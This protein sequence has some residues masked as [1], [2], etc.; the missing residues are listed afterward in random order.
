MKIFTLKYFTQFINK[1]D[2]NQ[3]LYILTF[4]KKM[5]Y[6]GINNIS[7]FNKVNYYVVEEM[8]PGTDSRLKS[9]NYIDKYCKVIVYNNKTYKLF[10]YEFE[11]DKDAADYCDLKVISNTN[12]NYKYSG[13]IFFNNT[14]RVYSGRY[15]YIIEGEN[16]FD[17]VDFY[18]YLSS[19]F[20]VLFS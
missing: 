9:L 1:L 7:E 13:N 10:A 15:A 11:S 20:T 8:N 5:E 16:H 4:I 12:Y 6:K 19:E 17:F 2:E 3:L 18:T 14:L